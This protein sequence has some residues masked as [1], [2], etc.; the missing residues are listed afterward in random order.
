MI[1][2]SGTPLPCGTRVG[3]S[4][5]DCSLLGKTGGHGLIVFAAAFAL[6]GITYFF[7]EDRIPA[8]PGAT[9]PV[10]FGGKPRDLLRFSKNP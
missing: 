4:F 9:Y 3:I 6:L 8:L 5:F 7:V 2:K 1:L 10:A